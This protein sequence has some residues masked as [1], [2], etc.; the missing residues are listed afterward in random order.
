MSFV[1][2]A[3]IKASDDWGHCISV[4]IRVSPNNRYVTFKLW[5]QIFLDEDD[6]FELQDGERVVGKLCEGTEYLYDEL[7]YACFICLSVAEDDDVDLLLLLF[8][9]S[10]KK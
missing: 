8:D 6:V 1:D 7:S 10:D 9:L 4:V 3:R 2:L 5:A